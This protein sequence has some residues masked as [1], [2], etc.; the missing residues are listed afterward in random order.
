MPTVRSVL[1]NNQYY[2]P[3]YKQKLC[4]GCLN[5]CSLYCTNKYNEDMLETMYCCK[6]TSKSTLVNIEDVFNHD[7][8]KIGEKHH[9]HYVDENDNMIVIIYKEI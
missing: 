5:Y 4:H 6:N 8:N 3:C 2:Q 1:D 7:N 9:Y